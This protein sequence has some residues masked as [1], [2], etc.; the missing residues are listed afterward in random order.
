MFYESYPVPDTIK[1]KYSKI[2]NIIKKDF[3]EIFDFLMPMIQN[4]KIDSYIDCLSQTKA[5]DFAFISTYS[6]LENMKQITHIDIGPGL[7]SHAMWSVRGF[8]ASYIG[9]DALPYSYAVQR[10]FLRTAALFY[11][12]RYIDVIQAETLKVDKNII[13]DCLNKRDGNIKQ[14]PSWLFDYVEDDSIDLVTATWVLNE[15]NTPGILWLLSHCNRVLKPGGYLYIRDSN[16]LKPLRHK[17]KYDELLIDYGY[18]KIHQLEV[19][20]RVDFY[21]IPRIY[22]KVGKRNDMGFEQLLNKYVGHFG[23]TILKGEI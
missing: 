9:I 10:I 17:I 4:K 7:G 3:T 21:G 11:K 20:N 22:K 15:V 1:E 18:K 19:V 2:Y 23:K 16:V 14:V 6:D 8:N 12:L 13:I 5:Q